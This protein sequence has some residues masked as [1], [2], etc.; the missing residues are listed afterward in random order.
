MDIT[1]TEAGEVDRYHEFH[2]PSLN[3]RPSNDLGVQ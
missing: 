2:L 3:T 1:E